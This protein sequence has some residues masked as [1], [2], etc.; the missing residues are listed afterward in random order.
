MK[1]KIVLGAILAFVIF[2][3]IVF[4]L[5]QQQEAQPLEEEYEP[6]LGELPFIDEADLKPVGAGSVL[7]D[8]GTQATQYDKDF[9]WFFEAVEE[10][11]ADKCLNVEE[12]PRRIDCIRAIARDFESE[13]TQQGFEDCNAS[14]YQDIMG[15]LDCVDRLVPRMGDEKLAI[16]DKHF[17]D[18]ET[19]RYRCHAEIARELMDYSICEAI[20]PSKKNYRDN[21]FWIVDLENPLVDNETLEPPVFNT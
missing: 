8:C 16:C 7:A 15:Y 5:Y 3:A 12:R 2:S 20:P 6:N 11:D 4:V 18:D 9:C 17:S 10:F 1:T 14:F 21:C 13:Q 19:Q